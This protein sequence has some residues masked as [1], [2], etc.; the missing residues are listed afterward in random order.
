MVYAL[1]DDG[2]YGWPRMSGMDEPTAAGLFLDLSIDWAFMQE[3]AP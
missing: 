2:Q 1:K 3:E